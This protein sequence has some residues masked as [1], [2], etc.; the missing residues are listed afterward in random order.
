MLV[1]VS[2]PWAHLLIDSYTCRELVKLCGLPTFVGCA[3][4]RG[5]LPGRSNVELCKALIQA[6][7]LSV[8]HG[9]CATE[10][11]D[12]AQ[13]V[14]LFKK[15]EVLGTELDQERR[16]RSLAEVEA[17]SELGAIW[18]RDFDST[19]E[20][21]V[22]ERLSSAA[23]FRVSTLADRVH[24]RVVVEPRVGADE[25]QA[26]DLLALSLDDLLPLLIGERQSPDCLGAWRGTT[27][28]R[29]LVGDLGVL[30]P[31]QGG[32]ESATERCV[33]ESRDLAD[34]E[35]VASHYS[36]ANVEV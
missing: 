11:S 36:L 8:I 1:S 16:P 33:Q 17:L 2:R 3:D 18:N 5:T 12:V 19:T 4:L 20:R 25:P 15:L 30:R 34:A 29:P 13:H 23:D 28:L 10:V 32:D 21:V 35:A 14:Q 6:D 24:R 26:C 9:L 27:F 31:G 22:Y 7:V